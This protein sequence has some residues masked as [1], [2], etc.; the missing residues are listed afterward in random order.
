MPS[1]SCS[2]HSYANTT[3]NKREEIKKI[4][5]KTECQARMN[6]QV[7]WSGSEPV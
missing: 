3:P 4:K 6:Q 1:I 5:P 2:Q 7:K